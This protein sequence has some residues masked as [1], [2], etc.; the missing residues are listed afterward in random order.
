MK[1]IKVQLVYRCRFTRQY[2]DLAKQDLVLLGRV[3]A[4]NRVVVML[5]SDIGHGYPELYLV[6]R[7][8]LRGR[9]IRD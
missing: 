2:P 3:P 6:P 1:A 7:H 8:S 5:A 4:L 9:W